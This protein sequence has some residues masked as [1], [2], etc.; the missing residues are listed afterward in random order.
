LIV[1]V[2]LWAFERGDQVVVKSCV[3]DSEFRRFII[4]AT[5]DEAEVI[6]RANISNIA[7]ED[8]SSIRRLFDRCEDRKRTVP[9]E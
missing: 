4:N 1:S 3:F 9:L 5:L 6:K 8:D 7:I 2:P